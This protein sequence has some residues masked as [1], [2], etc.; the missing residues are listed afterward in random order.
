MTILSVKNFA[1]IQ[2]AEISFG[3]LTVLVGPQA[4]GK[5]L[6]LQ[7]F[8]VAKD[9]GEILHA[10]REAGSD[11]SS[12]SSILDLVL[13]EGMS[14][15]WRSGESEV[16]LDGKPLLPDSWPSQQSNRMSHAMPRSRSLSRRSGPQWS[17][18]ALI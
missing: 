4:S 3:D 6:V 11:I 5:S 12:A 7:W 2:S 18:C 17:S 10:L 15:A 14:A 1:Q 16:A 13:G 8:K 9:M